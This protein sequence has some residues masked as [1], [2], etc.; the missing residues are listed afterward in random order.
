MDFQLSAPL[1]LDCAA[2]CCAIVGAS[3]PHLYRQVAFLIPHY[4]VLQTYFV[5]MPSFPAVPRLAK[6][7][8]L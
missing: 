3:F 5:L 2:F 6:G 4:R 7:I 1:F 8:W